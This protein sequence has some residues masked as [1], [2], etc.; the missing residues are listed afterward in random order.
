MRRWC[1]RLSQVVLSRKMG[2]REKRRENL[3]LPSQNLV[4]KHENKAVLWRLGMTSGLSLQGNFKFLKH[5]FFFC[6]LS[7]SSGVVTV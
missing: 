2:E 7:D 5:E 4:C 6:P 1:E 3:P